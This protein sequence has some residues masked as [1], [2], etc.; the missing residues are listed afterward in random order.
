MPSDLAPPAPCRRG[1]PR[2]G[3]RPPASASPTR[4]HPR[5]PFTSP[6][7]DYLKQVELLCQTLGQVHVNLGTTK[8]AHV[9]RTKPRAGPARQAQAP[10]PPGAASGQQQPGPDARVLSLQSGCSRG[11]L[12]LPGGQAPPPPASWPRPCQPVAPQP[13]APSG[14]GPWSRRPR[15]PPPQHSPPHPAPRVRLPGPAREPN[16]LASR[17]LDERGAIDP[18]DGGGRTCEGR[19]GPE[20]PEGA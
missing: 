17:P 3:P 6:S 20:A 5:A 14:A 4:W 18:R 9:M 12:Q 13:V 8:K 1:P 11:A 15:L 7:R 19:K 10:Q 16:S 2:H